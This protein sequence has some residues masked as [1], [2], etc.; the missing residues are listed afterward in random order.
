MAGSRSAA[1]PAL[2]SP[3]SLPP[4]S[5][6]LLLLLLPLLLLF[7]ALSASLSCRRRRCPALPAGGRACLA[8][9][10]PGRAS[11]PS[12]G[13]LPPLGGRR[14]GGAGAPRALSGAAPPRRGT[15]AVCEQSGASRPR[16]PAGGAGRCAALG[17][18]TA[19]LRLSSPCGGYLALSLAPLP[20][21]GHGRSREEPPGVLCESVCVCGITADMTAWRKFK[22]LL[23]LCAGLL[24]AA[25]GKIRVSCIAFV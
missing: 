4:S 5:L 9:R 17:T 19:P 6:L 16:S 25:Q 1:L 7:L 18:R 10:G 8:A 23:V 24:T 2:L 22:S 21:G 14:A 12:P 13:A 3:R 20:L 11:P 15:D